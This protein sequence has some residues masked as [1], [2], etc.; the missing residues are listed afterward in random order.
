MKT[1]DIAIG[2]GRIIE[3]RNEVLQRVASIVGKLLE[4]SLGLFLC[5]GAHDDETDW[6]VVY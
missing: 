4:E 6:V 5:E 1:E 2:V 3:G